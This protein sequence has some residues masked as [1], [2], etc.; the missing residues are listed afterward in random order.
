MENIKEAVSTKPMD[1]LC[2]LPYMALSDK[3]YYWEC[4]GYSRDVI[5]AVS[6]AGEGTEISAYEMARKMHRAFIN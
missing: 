3:S 5:Q 2:M 4:S 1:D 6:V